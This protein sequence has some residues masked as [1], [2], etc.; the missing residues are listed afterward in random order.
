MTVTRYVRNCDGR[1]LV[2]GRTDN[3]DGRLDEV[4]AGLDPAKVSE[5][6]SKADGA[7]PTHPQI[8]NVIKKN[9]ARR[10]RGI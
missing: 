8:A 7:V 9:H 1:I 2:Q 6:H 3:A 4:N 10:R 5:G